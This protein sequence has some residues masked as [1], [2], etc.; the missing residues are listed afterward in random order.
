MCYVFLSL[1]T[2]ASGI[3]NHRV[4]IGPR[5]VQISTSV[6]VRNIR[7]LEKTHKTAS[8]KSSSLE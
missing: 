5:L 7:L 2:T 6:I 4:Y 8:S 3:G 1:P